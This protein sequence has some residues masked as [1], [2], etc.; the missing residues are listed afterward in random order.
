MSA[1]SPE[2]FFNTIGAYQK[3]AALKAAIELDL[4]T[5]IATGKR[6]EASE[7]GVR[8]L[9]DFLTI[10][11]FLTKKDGAYALTQDSAVFLD[12]RSPAYLGGAIDFLLSPDIMAE[13]NNL[14][15]V[16]RRGGVS[17]T[18]S[19]EPEHPMWVTFARAM[20]PLTTMPAQKIGEVV[21]VAEAGACKILDIAASHGTFGITLA[22]M[23]PQAQVTGLDWANVLEVAQE[24]AEAAGIADRVHKL[25]GSA[26]D[27]DFGTGYDLILITNFL[28]HFDIPTCEKF[29]RKVHAALAPAGRAVTLEFVPDEDRVSPPQP[30]SFSMMMLATTPA[31]DAYT[32]SEFESMFRNAGFS[33][34]TIDR[35][36]GRFQSII[37]S[38]K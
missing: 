4:F 36:D 6:P 15:D 37:V 30:A 31:G 21:N 12:R 22:K 8:I 33:A 34:S 13:C 24:N 28:H 25:P 16:V 5:C 9:C 26:F 38:K 35:L 29:L 20:A 18:G 3:S 11:G 10:N 32:F 17:G 2:L 19:T 7:R 14:A 1:P 27:V 23:N